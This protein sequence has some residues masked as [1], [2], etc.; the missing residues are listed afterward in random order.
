MKK[1]KMSFICLSL[2]SGLTA[3]SIGRLNIEE[4]TM[5][6][7]LG[8]DV[9]EKDEVVVYISSPVFSKEAKEK[10]EHFE[11]KSLSLR[12]AREHFNRKVTGIPRGGKMQALLI[13][14]K[15]TEHENWQSIL[16]LF[17][18]D[19]KMRQSAD[20]IIVNGSIN[21][22]LNYSPEDKPRLSTFIPQ[23][24]REANNANVAYRTTLRDFHTMNLEKGITPFAPELTLKKDGLETSGTVIFNNNDL[25]VD[26]L[27][28]KETQL[29]KMMKNKLEKGL[30]IGMTL[31]KYQK[32]YDV[33]KQNQAS[34]SIINIDRKIKKEIKNGQYQFT[35]FLT[36]P[37]RVTESPIRLTDKTIKDFEKEVKKTLEK[38]CNQLIQTFQEQKV[39]PIGFGI[40]ARTMDY[41]KWK[42]IEDRW[43][44]VYAD[45]Q[46]KVKVDVILV[47]VG[48][49]L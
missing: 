12:E 20:L 2:L 14:K 25:Y 29:L 4:I 48:I 26:T 10:N 36:V 13:S 46:I 16:D 31:N 41:Q 21:K 11:T 9:N 42:S 39:D 30:S 38:Q 19:F 18:R 5:E 17:Y 27:S 23:L 33:F 24:L 22:I 45:S 6:L 15:V 44:D 7:I 28:M 43:L 8:V 34:F 37:F 3:C 32:N 47:D 40:I 1:I 35:M 49:S